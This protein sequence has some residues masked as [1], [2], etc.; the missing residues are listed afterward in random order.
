[1][2]DGSAVTRMADGSAV[3]RMAGWADI[4]PDTRRSRVQRLISRAEAALVDL[5][6]E[7]KA[8]VLALQQTE[9]EQAA[10][11][12]A[13]AT[14]EQQVA[15]ATA[16]Q[17]ALEAELVRAKA[18]E[19][20]A[21]QRLRE[22]NERVDIGEGRRND[23]ARLAYEGGGHQEWGILLAG[24]SATEISERIYLIEKAN[25]RQNVVLDELEV[26]RTEAQQVLVALAAA[27]RRVADLTAQAR[28]AVSQAEQARTARQQAT[29]ELTRLTAVR[30]QQAARAEARRAEEQ[31]RLRSLQAESDRLTALLRA[32]AARGSAQRQRT[33]ARIGSGRLG[34]PVNAPPTSEFGMRFHPILHYA[35]LH[36]GMDFGAACGTPVYSAGDGVV[37]RAGG[38]GG[39]GNQVVI[40]HAGPLA[41]TYSHLSVI[42]KHSGTVRR[43]ELIGQV[44]TTGLSTGCHLHFEVR[45]NGSP[46]NPRG[47]L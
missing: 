34:Y 22:I 7:A 46:V 37:V 3:T 20:R 14:A 9:R 1:M 35:R 28:V 23:M 38:A 4:D 8:A 30:K 11:R 6:D 27:R 45:V 16:R 15:A 42:V 26:A 32:R 18:D 43:G 25:E 39:Y 10:A 19:A 29:E 5:S 12:A 33:S 41:T 2:A 40:A 44:G 31:E 13:L 24:G 47:Y 36:S 21:E 17:V